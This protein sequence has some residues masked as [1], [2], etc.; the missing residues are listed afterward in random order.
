MQGDDIRSAEGPSEEEALI[1][2]VL[3]CVLFEKCELALLSLLR[4]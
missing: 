3:S 2:G 1:V 4:G